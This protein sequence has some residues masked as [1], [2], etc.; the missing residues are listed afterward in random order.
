MSHSTPFI[1]LPLLAHVLLVFA[2]Y[3]KLG[4]EKSKAV[5]A[6][7]VN[8]NAAALDKNAW[9]PAVLKVSNNIDN[10]FQL[11]MLFYALT[12]IAF[13]TG[14]T[15]QVVVASFTLFVVTRY[16]HAGIHIT[17]N[18]V[19]HRYRVFLVGALLLLALTLWQ[20]IVLLI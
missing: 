20:V 18:Y 2:L 5:K 10:Q 1:F 8:R 14:N 3:I 19:P 9:P 7:E 4:I 12:F 16:I 6:G 13:L 17:S 15:G 11:P